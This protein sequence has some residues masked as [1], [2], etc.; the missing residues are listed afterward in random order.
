MFTSRA[1]Y[2][3]IL[4]ED[5]AADRL[6]PIG[7]RLGLIGDDTWRRFESFKSALA[8]HTAWMQRAS[9]TGTDAVNERL[10][11]L[12]SAII[13]DRRVSMADLLR[14]PEL[15]HDGVLSVASAGDVAIPELSAHPLGALVAERVAIAHK[16]AGYLERQ[17]RQAKELARYESVRL[18]EDMDYSAIR[19]LSTEVVEKLSAVKPRSLGQAA[20]ISG[21]T[22]VAVSMLMTH[23]NL[24][25][26]RRQMH[27]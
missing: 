19:G 12:G 5:N 8:E 9:V 20:R 16:Y 24:A 1:E 6:M 26:K 2:R 18:P 21:I 10:R 17:E 11:A 15:D 25:R 7:R 3:L 23:L 14:R 4:R 22:P 13:K 27:T